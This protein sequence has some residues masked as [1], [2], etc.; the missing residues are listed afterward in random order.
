MFGDG[1]YLELI[2]FTSPPPDDDPN[3]WAHKLPGWIDF[4]FLGNS[5]TPSIAEIINARADADGSG[6]HYAAEVRGGRT[7]E[8]GKVLEWLISAAPEGERGKLPFFCGDLT[9]RDWRVSRCVPP[10]PIVAVNG[11]S[12]P[13]SNMDGFCVSRFR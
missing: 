1:T 7:R 13:D 9:P 6:V 11:L 5:G 3:P 10:Y 4:A 2:H 8:D 12:P